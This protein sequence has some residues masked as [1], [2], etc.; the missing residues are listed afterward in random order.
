MRSPPLRVIL[1]EDEPL[2]RERVRRL[3]RTDRQFELVGEAADGLAAVSLIRER[4]PHIVLLDI[5]LPGLSGF[6]VLLELRKQ[7]PPAV[8]FVTA[9]REHAVRAFEAHAVDYLLKPFT[10]ERFR[11]AL[12]R[13][14]LRCVAESLAPVPSLTAVR[15]ANSGMSALKCGARRVLLALDDIL[16]ATAANACCAVFTPTEALNVS[17]SLGSLEARLPKDR[18]V[19]ISRF[20]LINVSQVIQVQPKS[21]GDQYLLLRNNKRL[22]VARTCRSRLLA[23]LKRGS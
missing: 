6:E 23:C 18:F 11:E 7:V 13:A 19:R 5:R 12:N 3:L 9:F 16:Y 4:R 2:A 20:A 15:R 17:E 10:A 22:I 8:I 14:R 21:H 1:A